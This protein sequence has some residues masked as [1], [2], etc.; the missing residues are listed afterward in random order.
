MEQRFNALG[1][2]Q[3]GRLFPDDNFKRIFANEN[4]WVS[5]KYLTEVCSQGSIDNIP[6]LV[7]IMAWRRTGDKPL[8]EAMLV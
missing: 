3:N 7:Q 1:Q 8:S 5:I 2:R 4:V 6:A